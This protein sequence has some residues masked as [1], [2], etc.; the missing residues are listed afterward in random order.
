M[1]ED[2]TYPPV[3][4]V[5]T[6]AAR[7]AELEAALSEQCGLTAQL[8]EQR[9]KLERENARLLMLN[10]RIAHDE[11][12]VQQANES[13]RK[14]LDAVPAYT[15]ACLQAKERGAVSVWPSLDEWLEMGEPDGDGYDAPLTLAAIDDE[16]GDL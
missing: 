4:D 7:V 10:E 5:T 9:A 3:T 15:F 12:M 2:Y 8:I 1:A 14:A 11:L 13:L 16:D 6:L